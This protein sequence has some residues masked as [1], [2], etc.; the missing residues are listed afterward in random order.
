MKVFRIIFATLFIVLIILVVYSFFLPSELTIQR[1]IVIK[2]NPHSIEKYIADVREWPNWSV[3]NTI[4]DSTAEFDFQGSIG[5]G[6]VM[7]WDGD[8]IYSGRLE[9]LKFSPGKTVSYLLTLRHG[10]FEYSG[11][12]FFDYDNGETRV[13]RSVTFDVGWN[14]MHK[15]FGTQLNEFLGEDYEK[16]LQKLK[17]LAEKDNPKIKTV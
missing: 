7:T 17:F 9:I 14:P 13:Y 8:M 1:E 2:A 6:S 3:W 10:E 16:E 12:F 15:I 11:S 4:V 5:E